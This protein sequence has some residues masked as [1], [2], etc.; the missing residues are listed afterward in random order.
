MA[1][2]PSGN[3]RD[4]WIDVTGPPVTLGSMNTTR[5]SRRG[6]S[7]RSQ[8][9]LALFAVCAI[10]LAL[11]T[12]S[13]GVSSAATKR[14]TAKSSTSKSSGSSFSAFQKCLSKH[15]LKLPARG[16]SGGPPAGFSGGKPPAGAPGGFARNSKAQA[17]F[18]QCAGLQPK[19]GFPGAGANGANSTAFASYRNCMKLHGVTVPSV[20]PGATTS[21]PSTV[22]T[23]SPT[24]Q[25][26]QAAC[27]V[28]LPTG[29]GTTP[30][31]SG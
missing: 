5:L 22:D 20:T 18:K 31:G 3:P 10:S 11:T 1:L 12:Y 17:A 16:A 24:Y 15:G 13:G 19:G 30:G 7:S 8:R 25:A 28:L 26:A 6:A 27:K 29:T 4:S 23:S 2:T 9:V 14:T 21:T